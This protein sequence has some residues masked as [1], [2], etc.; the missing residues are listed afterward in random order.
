MDVLVSICCGSD[1]SFPE[2]GMTLNPNGGM[3]YGRT[4]KG[5]IRATT[6]PSTKNRSEHPRRT[7]RSIP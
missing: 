3:L 2:A 4:V 1:G 5:A 7:S 6:A